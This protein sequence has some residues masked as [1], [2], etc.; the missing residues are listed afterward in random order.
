M[1]AFDQVSVVLKA[2]IY[3]GGRVSSRTILFSDG[4]KKTLGIMLA[5]TYTFSTREEELMEILAGEMTVLL[6]GSNCWQTFSEGMSFTVPA[7]SSFR[8]TI[9]QTVDYC[10]SYLK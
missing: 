10:C 3:F 2:N 9:G 4:E 8:L 1:T 6:P 7:D 5:G